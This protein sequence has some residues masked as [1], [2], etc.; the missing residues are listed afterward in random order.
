MTISKEQYM[1]RFSRTIFNLPYNNL[2]SFDKQTFCYLHVR[3]YI[4]YRTKIAHIVRPILRRPLRGA[5]YDVIFTWY[6][7]RYPPKTVLK[8]IEYCHKVNSRRGG[9]I[10]SLLYFSNQ[11]ERQSNFIATSPDGISGYDWTTYCQEWPEFEMK[12]DPWLFVPWVKYK[13]KDFDFF[14]GPK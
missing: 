12:S 7:K 11:I 2:D 9:T 5:D 1:D 3:E 4:E 6:I 14:A 8:G 13:N 10:N